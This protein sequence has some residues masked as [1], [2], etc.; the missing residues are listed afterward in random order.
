MRIRSS[1]STHQPGLPHRYLA[2]KSINFISC[3]T[4]SDS[5]VDTIKDL[6]ISETLPYRMVEV[7]DG[8]V[9]YSAH[10]FVNARKIR[11]FVVTAVRGA[12]G[13]IVITPT[14]RPLFEIFY[15]F[16]RRFVEALNDK[17]RD[18][19]LAYPYAKDR[20]AFADHLSLTFCVR[21]EI[22]RNGDSIRKVTAVNCTNEPHSS[23]TLLCSTPAVSYNLAQAYTEIYPS[24]A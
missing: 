13:D 17:R 16:T 20:R 22:R 7:I 8:G 10:T 19:M 11:T 9:E 4:L 12:S 18:S 23:L 3:D 24:S 1:V 21:D 14:S 6:A 2:E 15:Q 5:M